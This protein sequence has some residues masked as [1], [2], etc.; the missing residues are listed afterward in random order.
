MMTDC[1]SRW[2]QQ[3]VGSALETD[4]EQP[5]RDLIIVGFIAK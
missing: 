2:A 1:A 4:R 5:H 3:L